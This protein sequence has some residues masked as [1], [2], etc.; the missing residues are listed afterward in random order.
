MINKRKKEILV[1][2]AMQ[3]ITTDDDEQG[4]KISWN[5]N[6]YLLPFPTDQEEAEI[7][8]LAKLKD[9]DI[10]YFGTNKDGIIGYITINKE[11]FSCS[12]C[13]IDAYYN[14]EKNSYYCPSCGETK[15]NHNS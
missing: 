15:P 11:F 6:S 12:Y 13:K 4:L 3:H 2:E 5:R 8:P 9:N 10:G 7:V 1:G 14:E